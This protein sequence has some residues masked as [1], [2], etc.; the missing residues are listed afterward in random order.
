MFLALHTGINVAAAVHLNRNSIIVGIIPDSPPYSFRDVEGNPTGYDVDLTRALAEA[1]DL[2]VEIRTGPWEEI[3]SDL[4][5]GR[6]DAIAGMYYSQKRDELV[7]FTSPYIISHHSIF[8]RPDSPPIESEQDLLG[9]EIIVVNGDIMHEYL[10]ASGLSRSPIPA[11]SPEEAIAML[12]S[13]RHDCAVLSRLQALYWIS[14]MGVSSIEITG[15]LL[16]PSQACYAVREGDIELQQHIN[17]ALSTLGQ[18]GELKRIYDEWLGVLEPRGI[19]S[20]TVYKYL[21]AA[22]LLVVFLVVLFVVLSHLLRKQVALRTEALQESE[23]RFRS[24]IET[25]RDWIW[26]V[27]REGKHTF[28]SPAVTEILGY[29]PEEMLG[30]SHVELLHPEDREFVETQFER[31]LEERKGWENLVLRWRDSKGGFRCLESNAVA[32]FDLEGNVTGFRGVDRDVTE[33]KNAENALQ[34]SERRFRE[35]A[36]MLPEAVFETDTS[37]KMTF[38]NRRAFEL[39]GY[40]EEDLDKGVDGLNLI[41]PRDRE[42]AAMYVAMR[43]KGNDPG[44]VEYEALRKDG[45]TFPILLHAIPIEKDGKIT[46]FRGIVV[47]ISEQ[48]KEQQEKAELEENYQQSQKVES[49][50][51]LA[52]GVAHDLN[53]LL[54]PILGFGEI[55]MAGFDLQDPRRGQMNEIMKA[56]TRARDLVKQLLAFGR[57]QALD[58]QVVDLNTVILGFEKLLRRT[59]REDIEIRIETSEEICSIEADVGQLEQVLLN[60]AINAQD[61][62]PTGGRLEFKI[63]RAVVDGTFVRKH[64]GAKSGVFALL[65]V[66]DTGCGIDQNTLRHLFEPFYSTKG[67]KGTGLGLATVYGIVKQHDGNIWVASEPG[68]GT[69]FSVYLPIA[70][71]VPPGNRIGDTPLNSLDVEGGNEKILLVEDNEPV[72]N[73][74]RMTLLQKGYKVFS[75]SG[76]SE[77]LAVLDSGEGGF[78]LLLTDV[79]MPEMNGRDL[80]SR[81]SERLPEIRVLYMSGYTD[82]V[83]VHHGVLDEGIDFIQ[84]P[85]TG[86][87]LSRKVREV[88]D[89]C[90]DF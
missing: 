61:A 10:P 58:S 76:G 37:L 64:Q 34:A 59:I 82:N 57:K 4:E 26:A 80:Y 3:R 46:G 89:G 18:T 54:T 62:M 29:A 52:G 42:G 74:V 35:L 24:I 90:A 27:D 50:G 13:G 75:A 73:M 49:L 23:E 53:N 31:W 60:L 78:D 19:P 48:K 39:F 67:Q 69:M 28:S 51:R 7:D 71:K 21:G 8:V 70:D 84:K 65:E 40:A 32:V 55:L 79:V 72:R 16:N 14:E 25:S 83:I 88:L 68:K 30:H 9:K 1:M 22:G 11:E 2:Q 36:E 15:P 33:R 81:V 17:E 6:I 77:A 43:R 12:V 5:T 63:S 41:A 85:F 87:D 47:D 86:Q 66:S 45:S 20:G 44:T 38:A 56:G